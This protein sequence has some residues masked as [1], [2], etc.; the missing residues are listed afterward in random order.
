MVASPQAS[1]AE[2]RE[3]VVSDA[4]AT[5]TSSIR[6]RIEASGAEVDRMGGSSFVCAGR[7]AVVWGSNRFRV[8]VE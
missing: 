5:A 7:A 1:W 2:A 4:H 6:Q 8:E 3:V